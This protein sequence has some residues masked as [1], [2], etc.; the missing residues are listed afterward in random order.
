[1]R[2]TGMSHHTSPTKEPISSLDITHSPFFCLV[3][4]IHLHSTKRPQH[5]RKNAQVVSM[6]SHT[7]RSMCT[8][9]VAP[10]GAML[11]RHLHLRKPLCCY[12]YPSTNCAFDPTQSHHLP[13]QPTP[14]RHLSKFRVS[15]IATNLCNLLLGALCG[16]DTHT[17]THTHTLSLSL[18]LPLPLSPLH[19]G[20]YSLFSHGIR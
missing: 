8:F 2:Y 9:C 15:T 1:M 4:V 14:S 19:T 11:R 7:R 20:A 5:P 13:A 3:A 12:R 10:G 6:R 18:P 17:Q 16:A